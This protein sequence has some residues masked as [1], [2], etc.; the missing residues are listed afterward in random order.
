MITARGNE[1]VVMISIRD[2]DET[3]VTENA[4]SN[5]VVFREVLLQFVHLVS[6]KKIGSLT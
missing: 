4:E 1:V 5:V 2:L 6:I 3:K